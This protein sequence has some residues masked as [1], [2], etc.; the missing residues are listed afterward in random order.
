M[1]LKN[2]GEYGLVNEITGWLQASLRKP[3]RDKTVIVPP[4]DDAAVIKSPKRPLIFTTDM[5]FE[6]MHFC[7]S[8]AGAAGGRKAFFEAL[9]YKSLAVN[10]SDLSSMG[11]KPAPIYCLIGVGLPESIEVEDV[12]SLYRGLNKFCNKYNITIIGG[13]TNASQKLTIAITLVGIAGSHTTRRSGAKPGD[14]I[15]LSGPLG[16]SAAGLH[17]L[18]NPVKP[19]SKHFSRFLSTLRIRKNLIRKHFYPPVRIKEAQSIAKQASSMIDCS[20]GLVNSINLICEMSKTGAA[21]NLDL[22]PVSPGLKQY[23]RLASVNP[24]DFA[25]YGGEDYELIFTSKKP[26]SGFKSLGTIENKNKGIKYY[27]NDKETKIKKEK[28]YQHFK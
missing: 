17:V 24:M 19:R 23:S 20:D 2:L 6:D 8:W 21:I 11:A 13:D 25:L 26:L 15:Y 3:V 14:K 16:D 9:G 1:K 7:L 10:L 5:L 22:I 12:R 4:G 27:L 28:L 18:L